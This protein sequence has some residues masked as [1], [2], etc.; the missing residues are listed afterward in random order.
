MPDFEDAIEISADADSVFEFCS[1]VSRM[2]DYVPTVTAVEWR[3]DDTIHVT[4]TA[5][6]RNYEIEGGLSVHN[7]AL[8]MIWDAPTH[9]R[10]H[11]EL[12][13]AP[14]S[15]DAAR[16]TVRLSFS[17]DSAVRQNAA[18][19]GLDPDAHIRQAIR[20]TLERMKELIEGEPTAAWRN[21]ARG[22]EDARRGYDEPRHGFQH[23]LD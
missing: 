16:V 1:D 15:G 23:P 12:E 20:R 21:E 13:V 6:E 8:R 2:P 18:Q 10:Y 7:E 5:Y 4:G 17:A 3:G 14:G 9:G 19:R 22:E 11:G